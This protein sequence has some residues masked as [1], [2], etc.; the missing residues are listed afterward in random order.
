M[1]FKINRSNVEITCEMCGESVDA[2]VTG[3]EADVEVGPDA[4]VRVCETDR[5]GANLHFRS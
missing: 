2:R 3:Y 5:W 4:D 1:T